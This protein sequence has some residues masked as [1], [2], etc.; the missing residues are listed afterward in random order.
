MQI[1]RILNKV[2]NKSYIGS[3]EASFEERY[4]HGKWW[5]WTHGLHLKS[6]VKKYGLENF[7]KT[8][9]WEGEVSKKELIEKE[10]LFILEHNSMMPN[11]YNLIFGGKS[12]K[13]PTHVKTYD[14]ID[15]SGNEIKVKNLSQFCRD[16]GLNYGAMLNMVSGINQ[17][18]QG[19]ALKGTDVS[20]ISFVEKYV[21]LDNIFTN[22]SVILD[23][24]SDEF[25]LFLEK[26]GISRQVVNTIMRK[27]VISKTGW[28]RFGSA[29]SIEDYNGPKHKATLY[30]E[31]GRVIFVDNVYK[32][33]Q[34]NG[35]YRSSLYSLISGKAL[36]FN[37]WSLSPNKDLLRKSH[38]ERLG[39]R[40]NLISPD[41][42]R[43]KIK[44][45]SQFCRQNKFVLGR[46]YHWIRKQHKENFYGWVLDKDVNI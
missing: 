26:E 22:E 36:V 44:N 19:F 41:G 32:F 17:S 7:E 40:I 2:N 34:E 31:D 4:R 28:K 37:G 42:E 27:D 12:T 30:H 14:L 43:I 33:C 38:L 8:I 20:K 6:A 39:K 24:N 10:K 9:L 29:L 16:R 1:Y 3:T 13:L 35:F 25:N 15:K 18:S 5:K 46:F 45:I 11:G 21:K 23:R